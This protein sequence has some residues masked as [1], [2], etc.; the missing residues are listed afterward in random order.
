MKIYNIRHII[1]KTEIVLGKILKGKILSIKGTKVVIDFGS[2]I[3]EGIWEANKPVPKQGET[4]TFL[5]KKPANPIVLK[6]LKQKEKVVFKNVEDIEISEINFGDE[7]SKKKI[8]VLLKIILA[9][10]K[11]KKENSNNLKTEAGKIKNKTHI[12]EPIFAF[13]IPFHIDNSSLE[14]K[15]LVS[16][17]HEEEIYMVTLLSSIESM[18]LIKT[19]VYYMPKKGKRL[20][21]NFQASLKETK[22]LVEKEKIKL[23]NNLKALGFTPYIRVTY[24]PNIHQENL[25]P[26][27][28]IIEK[29]V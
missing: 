16:Y 25:Y 6:A 17:D 27:K 4:L 24:N 20:I 1:P 21:V 9:S 10:V 2:F 13:N 28:S 12:E 18:G 19:D 29:R 15:L 26:H 23:E 3:G 8:A 11:I 5:V 14:I 22:E 7:E